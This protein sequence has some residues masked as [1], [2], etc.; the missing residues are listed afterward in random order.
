MT[1]DGSGRQANSKNRN[2][3]ILCF[4]YIIPIAPILVTQI[5]SVMA[6]RRLE[7][8]ARYLTYDEEMKHLRT[9]LDTV[10]TDEESLFDD[11]EET[12][13]EYNSTHDS[14]DGDT[15]IEIDIDLS[16]ENYFYVGQDKITREK[17]K[18]RTNKCYNI[19]DYVTIDEQQQP[20]RGWCPFRQ[21]MPKKPARYGVKI[22][23]LVDL[24]V[25]YTWKMEA[26]TGQQPKGPFQLDNSL[27]NVVKH[28]MSPLYNSGRN[29]TMDNWYTSYPLSQELLKKK[30]TVVGTL[31]KNKKEIPPILLH[32]KKREV[33]SSL[34]A[35]QKDTTIVSYVPK[36]NMDVLLLSKMHN[37]NA[38]D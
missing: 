11:E 5:F 22:F 34:F 3:G 27:G 2:S 37:D 9:L 6:V 10:L 18:F 8:M 36:K 20:F 31:R 14:T 1:L 24:R 17:E 15:D 7:N 19:G 12:D 16:N 28:L 4:R 26:Y 23:T 33:C 30:I 35:F 29:L 13:D 32:S 38:I 21:Y 25:F